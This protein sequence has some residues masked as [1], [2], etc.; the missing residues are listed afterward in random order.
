[1]AQP[2]IVTINLQKIRVHAEFR[3]SGSI[4]QKAYYDVFDVPKENIEN[5]TITMRK[6]NK[7]V[8]VKFKAKTISEQGVA[9]VKGIEHP[10]EFSLYL[11]PYH[12]ETSITRVTMTLEGL[13]K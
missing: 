2:V 7:E 4:H 1:M 8:L 9:N 13:K 3:A 5:M 11:K 10:I 6:N 12:K